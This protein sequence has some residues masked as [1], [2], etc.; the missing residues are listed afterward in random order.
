MLSWSNHHFCCWPTFT[1]PTLCYGEDRFTF[2]SRSSTFVISTPSFVISTNGRNLHHNLCALLGRFIDLSGFSEYPRN[3]NPSSQ[4]V[5]VV[6]RLSPKT[7]Q[8][9]IMGDLPGLHHGCPS[10]FHEY[11]RNKNPPSQRAYVTH[12]LSPK[13]WLAASKLK[14]VKNLHPQVTKSTRPS[15]HFDQ[16]EKSYA[17]R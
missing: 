11:P 12:R 15:C 3:K 2:G 8:V 4:R 5:H 9:C 16:R 17:V 7:W 13:T 14:T 1:R 6:N 10:G